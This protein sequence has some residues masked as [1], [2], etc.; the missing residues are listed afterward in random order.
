MKTKA[1]AISPETH[2]LLKRYCAIKGEKISH[3][4]DQIIKAFLETQHQLLESEEQMIVEEKEA[5]PEIKILK[6]SVL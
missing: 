2:R 6:E 5:K 1:L 4:G 3:I